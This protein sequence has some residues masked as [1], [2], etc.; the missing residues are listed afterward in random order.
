MKKKKKKKIKA[1][2]K[3]ESTVNY[4]DKYHYQKLSMK[5]KNI[6]QKKLEIIKNEN[7]AY[8]FQYIGK[9]MGTNI[10]S[11]LQKQSYHML[12]RQLKII[13]QRF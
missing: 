8:N 1:K 3:I 7:M 4:L 5:K 10:I 13:G 9:V 11:R 6:K 12:K 2:N